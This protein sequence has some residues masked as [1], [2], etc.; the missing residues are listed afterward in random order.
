VNDGSLA[1]NTATSNV[2][3]VGVDQA[4][5]LSGAGNTVTFT[6]GASSV[7]ASPGITV[8]SVDNLDLD[9]ATV[10]ISTGFFAGDTLAAVTT[11][12]TITASYNAG[13]GVLTLNG[14]DTLAHYQTVLDSVTFSSG[15]A[16]PT[17]F[18]TDTSRGLSWQV[19]DGALVSSN[20]VTSNVTVVGVDQAPELSGAGNTVTFTQGGAAVVAS[21]GVTVSDA[22]S[23]DLASASVSISTGFFTGDTLAAVTTGTTITASYNAG[24]GV[25][26]LTG[27]D[28]VAHYQQ[29]LDSVTFTSS[30][31]NPT[32]YGTNASRGLSWQI[33]DGTLNSN[34][35]TSNVTVAGVD[36]APVLAGAGNTVTFTE[37]GAA[38]V[39]S[40]GITASSVDNLD[41]ASASVS[42]SSGLF[43]GDTLAA[44]T[45]GTTITASYNATTGVLSL[46]GSDTVAHYQQVL[47]SVTF[48]SS[49]ANPTNSGA[50]LSR[51]LSWQVN[52]GTL[53]SN[54]VTSNVSVT[55]AEAPALSGASNT[56]TYTEGGTPVIASPAIAV[57]DV[58]S[59]TLASATVTIS[60]GLFAGD[61]LAAT[62]GSS[63]ITASYNA[64]TGVLTLSGTATLAAYQTVLE[65]V[66]FSST[67]VNPTNSGADTS[68]TLTWQVN[69]GTLASNVVTSNVS[70][71]EA[72]APVLAGA[73]NTVTYT[74]GGAA[75]TAS[76]AITVTDVESTTLA[77]ATVSISTG[78]FAGDALAAVT[79]GT[80]I[81]ASYNAG[82]GVLT[83]TGSDTVAH[84]QQVLDS[85]T[86]TSSS[87][88]PT[89]YGVDTSRGLSWQVNDGSLASNTVT[90]N[91]TVVGVDQAPVLAGAGNTV[92]FT[93]GGAAVVASS[94]VTVSDA[95]SLDLASATVSMLL[96]RRHPGRGHH[97]NRHY[98]E[99]QRRH[100]RADFD[101]QRHA[102]ALPDGARL[103]DLH[104]E[105]RQPDQLWR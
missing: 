35:V 79:T 32:N 3:V 61:T 31:A 59:T 95:D 82:T 53:A 40:S 93:Q 38:V 97:R 81:T 12:T 69:D 6:Q 10:S 83:L 88:N 44:V 41:L 58:E 77:S 4:P 92:T 46:T 87:A 19:K 27:S 86:F 2:T 84:Y 37:G 72:E 49:S 75:I 56:V 105:Q 74:Q 98:G 22:D 70:V 20:T 9:V 21:S 91:V 51:T 55:E 66:T 48:S 73:G 25:L 18:G 78:F 52:D 8:S 65:S 94:G 29:V 45:T 50:D 30:S 89:N 14:T 47:D 76:A 104:F 99:L 57:A 1:S 16:N 90:S 60:S 103:G 28:T 42:I 85:V 100:G 15:S 63:G 26:T 36:Q 23:L 33:N 13:T 11:G 62:T 101:R 80:A 39:A 34:T 64:T 67:S 96:H 17:N 5:V 7:A 24:T 54:V 68:R 71:T 102:G 43:A